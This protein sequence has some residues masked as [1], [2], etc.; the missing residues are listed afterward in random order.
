MIYSS[1]VTVATS[2]SVKKIYTYHF[3]LTEQ[4]AN[5]IRWTRYYMEKKAVFLESSENQ[6]S[7]GLRRSA[8]KNLYVDDACDQPITQR[9]SSLSATLTCFPCERFKFL[10]T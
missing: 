9:D 1:Y 3:M 7:A 4:F 10:K 5:E 2:R 6:T 8:S